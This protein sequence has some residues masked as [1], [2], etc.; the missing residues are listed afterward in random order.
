MYIFS[1]CIQ[2]KRGWALSKPIH[3]FPYSFSQCAL[4][5]KICLQLQLSQ[6]STHAS[7]CP[8]GLHLVLTRR[9]H[10]ENDTCFQH[11]SIPIP[12][13][14]LCKCCEQLCKSFQYYSWNYGVNQ[15]LPMLASFVKNEFI[16]NRMVYIPHSKN[17]M[18]SFHFTLFENCSL[19]ST[20]SF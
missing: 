7:A 2:Q 4:A 1:H 15:R 10:C 8:A 18:S 19:I 9:F 5:T 3:N 6:L 20:R 16:S 12:F 17:Q 11:F 14:P 13:L